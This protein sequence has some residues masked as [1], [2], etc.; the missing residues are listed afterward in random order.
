MR[1]QNRIRRGQEAP[2]APTGLTGQEEAVLELLGDETQRRATLDRL[3]TE[4]T[5]RGGLDA[6]APIVPRLSDIYR[7]VT[8]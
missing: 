2:P 3:L 1:T 5:A 7:E 6:I 8:A 4:A